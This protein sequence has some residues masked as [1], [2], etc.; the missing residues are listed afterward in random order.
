MDGRAKPGH[1]ERGLARLDGRGTLPHNRC[2][3]NLILIVFAL[4]YLGMALGYVPGLKLDRTG[5]ALLAA[6][7]LLATG[8]VNLAGVGRSVDMPTLVLLFGL[9]ILSSQFRVAGFYDWIAGKV[10]GAAGPP[11]RLLAI[12]VIVAGL[13]SALLANDIIAFAF[14]PV[15]AA[16]THRR[17][18]DARPFLIALAASCNAGSAMTVIGNPQNI[19]IGQV[20]HLD[21]LR[22]LF[23]CAPVGL[24]SLGIVY[25]VV[26]WQWR[27]ELDH[28]ARPY[29]AHLPGP[30]PWQTG[31]GALAALVLVGMFVTSLPRDLAA[32]VVAAALLFSRR[33]ASRDLIGGVDWGLLLLFA[34]LFVVTGAFSSLGLAASAMDWLTAHQLVPERL[35]VMVPLLAALGN[36]ISNVPSVI[37]ILSVWHQPPAGAMYAMALVSTLSGNLLIVGS[38][39]NII[40]AE[41]AAV[42]GVRLGFAD[43][44]RSGIPITLLSLAAAA[45]W[46]ALT[47]RMPL[48]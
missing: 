23:A 32:L 11:R 12:V 36:T 46:L 33:I 7:V 3:Q 8:A 14:A 13:L 18:L 29:H 35:A 22:F 2:V 15:I 38:L 45:A 20:G 6:V 16:G 25:L 27:A 34:C 9:M 26:H 37:L 1:D 31:K 17:G 44:A 21:F 5:L 48:Y 4:T 47:G 40:V 10:A 28:P 42:A 30:D 19:L 24:V 43:H 41:R 39:A